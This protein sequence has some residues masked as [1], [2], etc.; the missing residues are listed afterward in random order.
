MNETYQ[1]FFV[2]PRASFGRRI[3]CVFFLFF[4]I[5]FLAIQCLQIELNGT[6]VRDFP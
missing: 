2:V 1:D 4:L 3:S 5:P 6:D